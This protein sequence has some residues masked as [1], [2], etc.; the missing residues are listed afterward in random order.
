MRINATTNQLDPISFSIGRTFTDNILEGAET[1]NIRVGQ[2]ES[3]QVGDN[4]GVAIT[5]LDNTC[6]YMHAIQWHIHGNLFVVL[7]LKQWAGTMNNAE[8]PCFFMGS[9][10]GPFNF[11]VYRNVVSS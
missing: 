2:S 5:I 4:P 9:W 1:F 6:E 7:P 8:Q 10:Y 11:G 3:L